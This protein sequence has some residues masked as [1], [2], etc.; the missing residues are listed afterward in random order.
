M[1]TAAGALLSLAL[2]QAPAPVADPPPASPS[3]PA[4][5]QP[6]PPPAPPAPS[7]DPPPLTTAFAVEAA[8]RLALT[9]SAEVVVDPAA[10]FEMELAARL[11][12]ARLVLVDGRGD[13]VPATGTR[14]VGAHT[15][16]TLQPAAPLTPGSRYAL[17]LD[18]SAQ[19]ELRDAGGRSFA[20]LMLPILAAGTPPPPEPKR[21]A[22]KKKRR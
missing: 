20:P 8:A 12:D 2:L 10:S 7:F 17:R 19:R 18:G 4:E 3:T 22:R 16:L 13:L 14:E 9:P 21:P 11:V 15:R 5:P 1:L 6:Q